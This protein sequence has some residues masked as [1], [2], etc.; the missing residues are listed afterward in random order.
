MKDASII[1]TVPNSLLRQVSKKVTVF[2]D[3]LKRQ[4]QLMAQLLEEEDGVGLA[5][6]QIGLNN[7]VFVVEFKDPSGKKNIPLQFFVNPTIVESSTAEIQMN[8]GCL[9]VPKI[10]LPI[11]RSAKI[12]IKAQDLNGRKIKMAADGLLARIILHETDH[13]QGKVFTD[14]ARA[15]LHQENPNL[16][17]LK[18][19][20]IGTGEF[21]EMILRGLILLDLNIVKIITE[22][23]KLA[24]RNRQI[25]LSAVAQT[26]QTFKKPLIE[27]EKIS[28]LKTEIQKLNPD[29]ILLADFGQI[30][31]EEILSIPKIAA[32]NIHPSLLPKYRG[33]SP[34]ATAILNGEKKT[35]VTIMKMAPKIDA[36][37]IL[38]QTEIELDEEDNTLSLRNLLANLSLK[39]LLEFLPKLQIG[40]LGD[41]EVI[42]QNESQATYSHKFKKEDGE[43]DWKKS[44]QE[45]DRQI[46][47]LFGWPG[48]YTI[49][50]DKRLLIHQAHVDGDKLVLDVVQIEGKS[51]VMWQDFWRGYKG[52]KPDWLKK[53]KF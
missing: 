52:P 47:A 28:N 53:I 45:I 48:T 31:P 50:G 49:I 6:T 29:L 46:R 26:A 2:D 43:I 10:E 36:G 20:F 17:N 40:N 16:N 14:H 42:S 27:T 12:K 21:S 9:S 13:L 51:P 32:I 4:G 44:A 38:A 7:S 25:C 18:I 11:T 3:T 41:I 33:P 30:I 19:V 8:E 23:G 37:E 34:I 35:G 24:G 22:K 39:M 1:I 15:K 5:A